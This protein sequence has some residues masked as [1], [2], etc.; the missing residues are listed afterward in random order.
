MNT[1]QI[2]ATKGTTVIVIEDDQNTAELLCEF[3]EI[4]AIKVLGKGYDGKEA[5]ELY[6]KLN[7]DIVFI[8]VMMPKYDGFYALEQI[9][10]LDPN[11][12][13]IMVTADLTTDT[14]RLLDELKATALIYKPYEFNDIMTMIEKLKHQDAR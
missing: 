9:R 7:P 4:K 2:L 6:S 8:D 11:A 12:K 13:I 3:L 10:K 5:V 1:K 14:S